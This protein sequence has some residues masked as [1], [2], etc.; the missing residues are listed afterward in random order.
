MTKAEAEARC[1]ELRDER[2]LFVPRERA[3]GEWEV[4]KVPALPGIGRPLKA[5]TEAQEKPPQADDPRSPAE[6]Q[7][8]YWW[9]GA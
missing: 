2:S 3:D 7:G 1:A 4:V 6:R 8:M 5:T 9:G